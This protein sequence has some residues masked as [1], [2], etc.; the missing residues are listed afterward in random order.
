MTLSALGPQAL[1]PLRQLSSIIN[2]GTVSSP[3]KHLLL[4]TLFDAATGV[5]PDE[6][7]MPFR[8]LGER[9]IHILWPQARPYL[10]RELS[11]AVLAGELEAFQL[12]GRAQA[13]EAS[14]ARFLGRVEHRAARQALARRLGWLLAQWPLARLHTVRGDTMPLLYAVPAEWRER[15]TGPKSGRPIP[16]SRLLCT[17]GEAAVHLLP[18]VADLLY[19]L[20]PL[21][22]PLVE[23]R[24]SAILGKSQGQAAEEAHFGLLSHLFPAPLRGFDRTQVLAYLAPAEGTRCFWCQRS[25]AAGVHVDH[26]LP[27]SVSRND[28]VENLVL[29]CPQPGCT[30]EC[31]VRGGV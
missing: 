24:Y 30:D 2:D 16:R 29:T 27:W 14:L 3:Y 12:V 20:A 21:L 25:M 10:G 23:L 19:D 11:N 18:G 6:E 15:V 1:A 26:V 28:A 4:L 9:A 17:H 22:R 8:L 7:H 13:R 5:P 31:F